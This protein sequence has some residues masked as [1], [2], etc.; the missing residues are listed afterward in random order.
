MPSPLAV[1]RTVRMR[2][3]APRLRQCKARARPR[4]VLAPVIKIVLLR[5]VSGGGSVG[6]AYLLR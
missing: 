1:E 2:C 4:P 5:R 3:E 6:L